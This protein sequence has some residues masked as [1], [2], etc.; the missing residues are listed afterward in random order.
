ME[1]P[2]IKGKYTKQD[3][4]D[5]ALYRK[6]REFDS[7]DAVQAAVKEELVEEADEHESYR[8]P[9]AVTTQ[10]LVVIELSTGGDADGFKLRYSKDDRLEPD[11]GVYYWADWGVYEEVPLTPEEAIQVANYFDV[12]LDL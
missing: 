8:Y 12:Y 11:G 2:T 3:L 9:L 1:R 6:N 5:Y 7:M 4:E 10:F